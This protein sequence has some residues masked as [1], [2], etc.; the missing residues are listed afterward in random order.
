MAEEDVRVLVVEDDHDLR[1][2]ISMALE[3]AAFVPLQA[4]D[5]EVAIEVAT[6]NRIDL[7]IIDMALPGMNGYDVARQLRQSHPDAVLVAV[8]GKQRLVDLVGHCFHASI[9]KPFDMETLV[10]TCRRLLAK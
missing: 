9:P 7:A 4:P 3:V 1:Q 8:S 10:S 2:A 6:H 5:G